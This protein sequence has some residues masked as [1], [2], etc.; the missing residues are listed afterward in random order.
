MQSHCFIYLLKVEGED[1]GT[2]KAD[3]LEVFGNRKAYGL[4]RIIRSA[5]CKAGSVVVL[6]EMTEETTFSAGLPDA[7]ESPGT[8]VM[9]PMPSVAPDPGL[10]V[11]RKPVPYDRV[12]LLL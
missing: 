9:P 2:G 5:V 8:V 3:E 12:D 11:R 1:V 4:Q 6:T 7:S 10:A